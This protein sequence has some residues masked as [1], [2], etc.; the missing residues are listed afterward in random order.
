MT[1]LDLN[2][3]YYHIQLDADLSRLCTFVL[4]WGKYQYLRLPMGL[5]NS[6]D[7][8]KEKVSSIFQGFDF[9]R[10]YIHDILCIAGDTWKDHL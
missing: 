5:S 7:I 2:M 10:T 3:G 8:F 4:P 6:P 1:T 9:V